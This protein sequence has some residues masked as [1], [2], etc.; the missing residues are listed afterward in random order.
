MRPCRLLRT[1]QARRND[2]AA[3]GTRRMVDPMALPI[4]KS[5]QLRSLR[6]VAVMTALVITVLALTVPVAFTPPA[7]QAETAAI[8]N[9]VITWNTHAQTAIYETARQSPTGTT[10]SFAM[11]QGAVYDAVN[12]I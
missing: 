1:T 9:A 5:G 12:A 10:R 8:P 2:P 7:A 6:G 3:R 4:R 11:V